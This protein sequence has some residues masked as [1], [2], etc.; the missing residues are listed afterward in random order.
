MFSF[1]SRYFDW[2]QK[3]NFTGNKDIFPEISQTGE[4]NVKGIFVAGDLTGIPL[5]K[6]ASESGAALAAR[7]SKDLEQL[8]TSSEKSSDILDIVIVGAGPAGISAGVELQSRRNN[9]IILESNQPFNTICNFPKGKPI[10]PE[11]VN[12]VQKRGLKIEEGTKESLMSDLSEQLKGTKLPI[13][14]DAEVI[15][16]KKE[17]N[18]FTV[19][20][21]KKSYKALRIIL[22]TGKSGNPRRLNAPGEEMEKVFDR[23]NDPA[24]T[25]GEDVLIVGGGDS[26]L[27]AAI[28]SAEYAKSVTLSYRRTS[29]SRPKSTNLK[30]LKDLENEGKI[31]IIFKSVVKEIKKESVILKI[32]GKDENLKNS[33]VYKLIGRELPVDFFNKIGV[34]LDGGKFSR[35]E[36]VMFSSLLF[37][38]GII[39]FG[40]SGLSSIIQGN[41]AAT[42][43]DVFA[44]LLSADFWGKFLSY[45]LTEGFLK[46]AGKWNWISALNGILGYISFLGF[47]ITGLIILSNF[48]RN[49]S[50]FTNSGWKKIKYTYFLLVALFFPFIYISYEYFGVKFLGK[51]PG[52]WY[53]FL[54]SLTILIFGL[55]RIAKIPTKYIKRQTWTLIL[56]QIFPLF[57]LPEIILPAM[58]KAGILGSKGGFILTQIF[59]NANFGHAYRLILAWPLNIYGLFTDHIT[60]FWLIYTILFSFGLIPYLIYKWGKGAYCG[61]ICSC[62]A[63]AETLGDEYRTKAPHGVKAK[64]LENIGQYVLAFAFIITLLKMAAVLGNI[65]I[66]LIHTPRPGLLDEAR[67][68][69]SFSVD[70]IFAGVLGVG[71]YFFMSGRIWCRYFC[72]LA[73][74]MHIYARFSKFRIFSE[75]KRCISCNICTKVCHMGIDVMNYANK[76]IPMNDV[77]CVRCSACVVNCPMDVLYFGS[78]PGTDTKNT[79][80]KKT[81]IPDRNKIGWSSGTREQ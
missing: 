38:S 52:F 73:A 22:A 9:F 27:E 51:Y 71:V 28:A 62:G 42:I 74:L 30:K 26:A 25:E 5:L 75:K 78:L 40:K 67:M 80:Y 49:I 55:R 29:F 32:N 58:Y 69:Y 59:P 41:N 70:I 45:P 37:F 33:S 31:K 10:Y 8:K 66:P 60:A 16:I 34:K 76:G 17:K 68:I 57:L 65:K 11:P 46:D 15:S 72:P 63:L 48:L 23:L 79:E 14:K 54:Y 12:V 3:D 4:T 43:G 39:Y 77:E 18:I 19:K 44:S 53:T 1:I 61:W 6:L 20:T 47:V 50:T 21:G 81:G 35:I 2:L 56:I 7:M 13:E 36:K 24:E 64:K